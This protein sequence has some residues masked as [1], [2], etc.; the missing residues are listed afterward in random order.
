MD[1]GEIR[2]LIEQVRR[3]KLSRRDFVSKMAA[4]GLAAPMASMLLA[5]HGVAWP[6]AAPAYS[7]TRRGGGGTLRLISW[8]G[9]TL[10]QPHFA[11]GVKDQE[12]SR[13]FYEPLANWDAEGSLVP[14]LAAGIP[15]REN[16]G[17]SADGTSVTWKLKQGVTWHDGQP[18]TADDCVATWEFVSHPQAAT[19]TGGSYRGLTVTRVDSHTIRI[20][21][22]KPTP[23]WASPFVGAIGMILP[24]H[25]FGAYIGAKSREAPANLRPVGTGPYRFVD[26]R[27][28]DFVRAELYRDYHMPNR[29]YF[30]AV[31]IKGGGDATSA[32][33]AVLQTGD[34]DHAGNIL[35]EDDVLRRMEEG[36]TGHVRTVQGGDIE[37]MLL[38]MTDPWSEFEG[39]RAHAKTRHFAFSDPAVREAMSLLVD[40]A[41]LQRFVYGRSGTA[42]PNILNNPERFRSPNNRMVFDTERAAAL[43]EA[44]GWKPG[45]DG[46]RE[47]AGRRLKF[48]FQTSVSAPRQKAQ[49]VIKQAARA[50]GVELEL[51]TVIPSVYFSSDVANPNTYSKFW[52]DMQ[53]YAHPQTQPDPERFMFQ[54]RAAEIPTKANKWQGRNIARWTHPEYERACAAAEAELDPA[55]RAALFIR[56]NDIVV[57]DHA[58]I[59]LVL[60][61]RVSVSANDLV[62]PMSPWDLDLSTLHSWHRRT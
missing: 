13:I 33:R 44:A 29:P 46:I 47:K 45:A 40:R 24:R 8:Q 20:V 41:E 60:R 32:A 54:F 26:F 17:V 59:P 2:H 38:N 61:S 52:S 19:V 37:F 12:A 49:A 22:A 55:A 48:E 56:M 36:G 23:F 50:A 43:L 11:N 5:H 30:D 4:A 62:A 42:T 31:E 15:T 28:G 6:Q 58:V 10:L 1:V 57:R 35:V 53:M 39:E 7:P 34:F 16:G 18:F 51:K 27:P 9:S 14:V 3:A 21:F 25:H